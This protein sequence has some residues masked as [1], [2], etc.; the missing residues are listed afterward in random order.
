MNFDTFSVAA[1][2]T[3]LRN[4]L[5]GGRVQQVIQI[6]SLTYAF[7][8]YLHPVR[9]YLLLAAEP[10]APRLH[11]T[12]QRARRGVGNETPLM[13]V[14]RKYMR[15]AILETIEQPPYER[16]LHFQFKTRFGPITITIELL[17]TR[18]N[19]FLLEDDRSILGAA[20]L[21]K[22]L[23]RPGQRHLL[24]GHFYELPPPQEQRPPTELDETTLQQ[25]L[26]EASPS[27][28][29]ARLLP[30]VAL[31]VS[32]F[33]A[34]EMVY[35]ATGQVGTTVEQLSDPPALI[36]AF[37]ELFAH[38]WQNDW[39]PTLAFDEDELPL[40]F[41]PY[42]VQHLPGVRPV[43]HF[44]EAVETYFAEAASGYIA[45]KAPLSEAISEVR[46]RL[47][48][49]HERLS[50]DAALQAN[51]EAFKQM[52]EAI[53]AYAHEIRR[54]QAEFVPAWG[55]GD[56]P[57]TIKLDPALS[58]SDNAQ[59]YFNRYRKAQRAA[60][61]IPEQL[62]KIELEQR[63]LDQIEQDLSMAENRPEID[64]IAG[65]LTEAGYY[66]SRKSARK[67]HKKS[68]A[69]PLRLTAPDGATVW[70]G[71]N[72]LQNAELTFNRASGDD[73]WLHARALPGAH[74]IVPTAQGLPSEEDVF[75]AAGLAAYYSK[76]RR[77]TNVEVD[78]TLKKYVRAIKGA[79][80]GLVTY[81]HESTLRVVPLEPE[82]E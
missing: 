42:P 56:Q 15:G 25:E 19:L 54:G 5:L 7:E 23:A 28:K 47:A 82:M 3:E 16:V 67:R 21:P 4:T 34:R 30:Q 71:K 45:A 39:Q 9:H 69:R 12:E 37:H 43:E 81:R 76:A 78:V 57:P 35:R 51:P 46:A 70:V 72:A 41:A 74:V 38:F 79:A 36:D 18:S 22:G 66:K 2:A 40:A 8:I 31:G 73:L 29:L 53:L 68:G 33:L 44:S 63:F 48:R 49:R 6:N 26:A 50:Q 13:L 11:L 17:G 27:L 58:A 14:F 52:G 20:R 32:P 10:Q 55:F 80:P 64:S 61:E 75:W 24:P 59:Q 60:E 77:D 1:I 62:R 65:V